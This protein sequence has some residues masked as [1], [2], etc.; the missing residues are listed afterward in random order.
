[1]KN[2]KSGENPSE[3]LVS[4]LFALVVSLFAI[5]GMI[6]GLSGGY[7]ADKFGRLLDGKY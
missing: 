2:G 7:L 4:F 1:M 5:G 3:N 6:G